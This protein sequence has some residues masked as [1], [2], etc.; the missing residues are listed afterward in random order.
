MTN[1]EMLKEAIGD[2]G[3]SIKAIANKIGISREGLYKKLNN[4]TEFKASE[5]MAIADILRMD[6]KQ[7]DHIFFDQIGDFKSQ[8]APGLRKEESLIQTDIHKA[9]DEM[10]E[11]K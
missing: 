5:I 10:A 1:T 4:Q 2:S 11:E 3:I 7:R 9:D 8:E 6:A